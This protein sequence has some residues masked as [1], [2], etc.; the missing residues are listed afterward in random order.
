MAA[1][2]ASSTYLGDK[3]EYSVIVGEDALKIVRF[4]PPEEERFEAG[5]EVR[6]RFPQEGVQLLPAKA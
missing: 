2:V 4:D 6:I 1:R 5:E 3:I